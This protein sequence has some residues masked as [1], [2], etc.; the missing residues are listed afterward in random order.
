MLLVASGL[1]LNMLS[2]VGILFPRSWVSSVL[3]LTILEWVAPTNR[4]LGPIRVRPLVAM[5]LYA[6]PPSGRRMETMLSALTSLPRLL[7]GAVLEC[8]KRL[9]GIREPYVVILTLKVWVTLVMAVLTL[10]SLTTFT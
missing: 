10:F 7:I 2:V 6:V 1:R 4:A 9:G 3:D 5:T 8:L